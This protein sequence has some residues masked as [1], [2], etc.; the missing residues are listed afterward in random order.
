[1]GRPGHLRNA[2]MEQL[3][4]VT[5]TTYPVP[6]LWKPVA[7]V[8]RAKLPTQYDLVFGSKNARYPITY[9]E[10]SKSPFKGRWAAKRK[11]V[12]HIRNAG[13]SSTQITNAQLEELL[14]ADSLK[15]VLS[16]IDAMTPTLAN[17]VF[18]ASML[19][20]ECPESIEKASNEDVWKLLLAYNLPLIRQFGT[21]AQYDGMR[22]LGLFD[23]KPPTRDD[24]S[25]R[26]E[27]TSGFKVISAEKELAPREFLQLL[28]QKIFPA[29]TTVR[30]LHAILCGYEPD[31][32]HEAVGHLS[33]LTDPKYADFYQ[34]CGALFDRV[35]DR[36]DAATLL[37]RL[38]KVLWIVIEY[39]IL[40]SP[41]GQLH[42]F[43]GALC[44]SFMAL[45]RLK[46]GYIVTVP[47]HPE[48][49][50]LSR[51]ADPE[52]PTR[53]AKGKIELFHADSLETIKRSISEWMGF[54][55]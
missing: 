13:T 15:R 5:I 20:P 16:G 1:M 28:S 52:F 24:I 3:R 17:Q 21:K 34:W 7:F 2:A 32:W 49:V 46:L 14:K 54:D 29:V 48:A 30:P 43:G 37:S 41:N 44:A 55:N 51:L 40:K 53:R 45:Q 31:Y 23:S 27:K 22:T 42:A 4:E 50:L 19:T 11:A 12:E 25:L 47:F 33:I 8:S 35:K 39:G 36:P 9:T 6:S 10:I 26:L 38:F 18:W